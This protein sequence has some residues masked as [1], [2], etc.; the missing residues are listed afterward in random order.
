MPL[1]S[2][3]RP[4]D[5]RDLAYRQGVRAG[6]GGLGASANPFDRESAAG[7][8]WEAGRMA[9]CGDQLSLRLGEGR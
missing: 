8:A 6:R 3:P 4:E 9:I 5:L 1:E 2:P 7:R